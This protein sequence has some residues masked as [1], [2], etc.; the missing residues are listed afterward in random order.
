MT[1][2]H[3][4]GNQQ[5]WNWNISTFVSNFA[6]T[7]VFGASLICVTLWHQIY[8]VLILPT[9]WSGAK[10]IWVLVLTPDIFLFDFAKTFVF[11]ARSPESAVCSFIQCNI[12]PLSDLMPLH[13]LDNF[14]WKCNFH[15]P[16]YIIQY[17]LWK[18]RPH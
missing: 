18:S 8:L 17:K 1:F 4:K 3:I 5:V 9:N 15:S 13:F 6:E 14:S 2:F 11:G 7:F 10:F 16:I 12:N